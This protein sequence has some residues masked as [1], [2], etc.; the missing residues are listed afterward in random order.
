MDDEQLHS[1]LNKELAGFF[2]KLH[3]RID[4]LEQKLDSKTDSEQVGRLQNSMDGIAKRID[5]DDT[6]R[7][8]MNSQLNRHNDWIGQLADTTNTKLVPEQ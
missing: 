6:E 5:T 7:V 2:G 4:T 3:V 1:A 8:T